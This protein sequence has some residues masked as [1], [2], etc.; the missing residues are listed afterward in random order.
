MLTCR[1]YVLRLNKVVQQIKSV[2]LINLFYLIKLNLKILKLDC[3]EKAVVFKV[4]KRTL[5]LIC[6]PY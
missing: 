2:K 1:A 4:P 5:D 3:R 6:V